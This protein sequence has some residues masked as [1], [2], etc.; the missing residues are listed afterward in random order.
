[1]ADQDGHHSEMIT[2]L[3]R[4]VMSSRHDADVKGDIFRRT[5]YPLSFVVIAFIFS[6]LRRGGGGGGRNPPAPGRR[7]PKQARSK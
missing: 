4:H 5:I 2:Q 3:L 6:K 7:R 1:M